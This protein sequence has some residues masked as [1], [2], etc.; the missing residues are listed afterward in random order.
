MVP[1]S[2][3]DSLIKN[4]IKTTFTHHEESAALAAVA[5]AKSN[6]NLGCAVVTTGLGLQ[7]Q[8]LVTCCLAGFYSCNFY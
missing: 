4:K 7:M 1:Y 3:F 5:N 2:Y 8:L 6:K